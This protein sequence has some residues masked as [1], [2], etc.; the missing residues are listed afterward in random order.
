[1]RIGHRFAIAS[2][3]LAG[4]RLMAGAHAE[5]INC[6]EAAYEQAIAQANS[7]GGNTTI[8]FNCAAGTIIPITPGRF[9]SRVLTA[10]NVVIDGQNKV[11]FNMTPPWWD[12]ITNA[13]GG[14]DCDPDGDNVPNA[15]PDTNDGSTSMWVLRITGSNSKL[16]NVVYRNFMEGVRLEATGSELDGVTGIMPGDEN[17]S[18]PGGPNVIIRNSTF[19]NACDKNIQ[20]YG[21]EP[22]GGSNWDIQIINSTISNSSSGVRVS[23][24]GGRFLMDGVTFNDNNPP[25]SMF[26]S[27][28]PYIGDDGATDALAFYMKNSTV[29]GT[30]RGLR[31]SG[32]THYVSQGGNT[33]T[34]NT[35][36]GLSCASTS[37][38]LVQN[39]TFTGNGGGTTAGDPIMG[40]GGIAVGQ[41]AV[42]D[43]GGGSQ[44]IDGAVRSSTGNNTLQGNRSS[45]DTTLD[46]HNLTTVMMQAR[47]NW[48]GDADPADQVTGP[49]TT[50]SALTGPPGT[51]GGSPSPVGN[52]RRT[53]VH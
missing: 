37:R 40:Y 51:G 29:T 28:G 39:D 46:F 22:L 26:H 21:N 17:V 23:Y 50:S 33:F 7:S 24:S 53:D 9:S 27:K 38:C 8:T 10:P 41:N 5:Q 25:S 48:W 36:R 43:A 32:A 4:V 52:V 30:T 2:L 11:S 18:N 12:A 35:L 16:K 19:T 6:T 20:M 44:T 34:G 49:V 47:S 45:T 14:A 31:I 1:M 3:A 15:C 13:C 42:V